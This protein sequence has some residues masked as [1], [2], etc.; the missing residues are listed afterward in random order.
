MKT[1]N[2]SLDVTAAEL[3]SIVSDTTHYAHLY[4]WNNGYGI[5]DIDELLEIMGNETLEEHTMHFIPAGLSE[6]G[7]KLFIRGFLSN[8]PEWY[9]IAS[10]LATAEHWATPWNWN[11]HKEYFNEHLL[12]EDMGK[13]WA[14]RMNNMHFIA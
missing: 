4:I 12:P 13:R 7:K 10:D 8:A 14:Q 1:Y 6:S 11:K 9:D 2:L 3:H 5:W